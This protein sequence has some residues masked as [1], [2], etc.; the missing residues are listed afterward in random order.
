MEAQLSQDMC[1]TEFLAPAHS[2]APILDVVKG[3]ASQHPSTRQEGESRILISITSH[4]LVHSLR[5]QVRERLDGPVR[6][7]QVGH[8]VTSPSSQ[9][10]GDR[11]AYGH[12]ENSLPCHSSSFKVAIPVLCPGIS[13]A[14]GRPKRNGAALSEIFTKRTEDSNMLGKV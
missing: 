10:S 5:L 1:G 9:C 4:C 3:S 2:S 6:P 14:R 13:A 12:L 11:E 7:G 8:A